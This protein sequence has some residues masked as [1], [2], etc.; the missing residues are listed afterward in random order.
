MHYGHPDVFDRVFHLTRGGFS[1]ASRVINI[2]EDIYAGIVFYLL[3]WI[4]V[5]LVHLNYIFTPV[6]STLMACFCYTMYRIH[7]Y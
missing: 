2:S 6:L 7:S 4:Y 1:K 3:E 5:D